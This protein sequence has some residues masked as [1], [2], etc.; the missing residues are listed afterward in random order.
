[1]PA[2]GE[3]T[4]ITSSGTDEGERKPSENSA[5]YTELISQLSGA[6]LTLATGTT[7]VESDAAFAFDPDADPE[8]VFP[9]SVA[10]GDPS[11]TGVVI[12]TRLEPANHDTDDPLAVQVAH[13]EAFEEPVY[14]AVIEDREA[15]QAH[16]HTVKLDLDGVLAPGETY[17]YRFIHDGV[18]SQTGRCRTLPAPDASPEDVSFAVL[19]CQNYQNGYF[20]AYDY[21]AEED[22]DF[23]VHVGDFI[24]EGGGTEFC[25][26]G[27]PDLPDRQFELP[28]GHDRVRTLEDYRY[29][30]RT[31]R[32]DAHLQKAMER[33]TLI[34]AWDDHEIA[35]DVYWDDAVDAPKADHP[36]GDDPAFMTR[37]LADAIHAWWEYMPSRIEYDPDAE[38]LQ[39]RFTMWREFGFGDLVDVVMTDER[40]F[41]D[42]PRE[43]LAPLKHAVHPD[44][45]DED[46]SMLGDAQ[47]EWFLDAVENA[48]AK[49]TCWTDEVLTIP[50]KLGAG[51]LTV[52]PMQEGWD[53]YTRERR[54]ITER[55]AEMD[56]ENFVTLTG[57]MHS[58]VAGYKQTEY[59]GPIA[60]PA[61]KESRVGVEFMTPAITS[62]NV[63]EALGANG[64][65]VGRLTEPFLTKTVTWMNPHI[66]YINS[67][68]WGYSVVE[69]T[70]EDCTYTAYSVDKLD[71]S[72]GADREVQVAYR[73]PDGEVEL[74][75]VTDAARR[76]HGS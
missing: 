19:T 13:D 52:F 42:G 36:R 32:S 1:M 18:A 57:D 47:R 67:H 34:P 24:Y 29:L 40:L 33:H 12:W 53:G 70:R 64:G 61:P 15:V 35:N 27:S 48:D 46:R 39:D 11:P 60:G 73:V 26:P 38:S 25:G 14:R 50:L 8:A 22:V 6:D 56:I 55:I 43:G 30:Y 76:R 71:D 65:L 75:D 54:Y 45:E 74:Q 4:P 66:E 5:D 2:D 49:W 41:R 7:D 16:D 68:C 62:L 37:L 59:G 28:S 63:A 9:Q 69:F 31:Y 72:P 23:I 44:R 3:A 58:Y 51:P 17:Y 10:S 20:S 21:I